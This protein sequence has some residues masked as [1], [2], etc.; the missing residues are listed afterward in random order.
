[1][2]FTVYTHPTQPWP[3][4][5]PLSHP[6]DV[7]GYCM[8][9]LSYG[10][11]S[12][13]DAC[14]RCSWRRLCKSSWRALFC[15]TCALTPATSTSWT[16]SISWPLGSRH[17]TILSQRRTTMVH[18]DL[19]L[20]PSVTHS[21][22][23]NSHSAGYASYLPAFRAWVSTFVIARPVSSYRCSRCFITSHYKI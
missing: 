21:S 11:C 17:S 9:L 22:L 20:L 23:D 8:A 14:V 4:A 12:I 19:V 1:M 13:C 5:T 3:P 10:F 16:M 2:Y 18:S 6:H 7:S 15:T